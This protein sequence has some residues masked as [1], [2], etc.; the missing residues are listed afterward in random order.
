M[1]Y[2]SFFQGIFP[3][4]GFNPDLPHC[5]MMILYHLSHQGSP[6]N[7]RFDLHFLKITISRTKLISSAFTTHSN[8]TPIPFSDFI[9]LNCS[10]VPLR[11][12][13][14]KLRSI[15]DTWLPYFLN[16]TTTLSWADF[17]LTYISRDVIAS[18][19]DYTIAWANYT[20]HLFISPTSWTSFSNYHLQIT[21]STSLSHLK[22]FGLSLPMNLSSI[23]WS[24]TITIDL[25]PFQHSGT[26]FFHSSLFF[27]YI[28]TTD[29]FDTFLFSSFMMFPKL[30]TF[31]PY[32]VPHIYLF[33][34]YPLVNASFK[35]HWPGSQKLFNVG[36]AEILRGSCRPVKAKN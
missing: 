11:I 29:S 15:G 1:D 9:F 3:T 24:F 33:K 13:E 21:F 4:Q 18:C 30:S 10:L 14:L 34:P 7:L 27:L 16:T 31:F 36:I 26:H 6:F 12:H 5:R 25:S 20:P 2:N 28:N 22:K 19:L 17:S 23:T 8:K 35:E 32:H